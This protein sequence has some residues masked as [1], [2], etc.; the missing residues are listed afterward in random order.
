MRFGIIELIVLV[1]K[2]IEITQRPLQGA[3]LDTIT[4]M[5]GTVRSVAQKVDGEIEIEIELDSKR[6]PSAANPKFVVFDDENLFYE[7]T[8]FGMLK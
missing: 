7:L 3:E 5:K 6:N 1:D 2:R 8:V 4:S